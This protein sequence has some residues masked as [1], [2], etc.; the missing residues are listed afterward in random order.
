MANITEQ[1]W[2]SRCPWPTQIIFDRGIEFFG[3]AFKHEVM[4]NYGIKCKPITFRKPQANA[5]VEQ[6]HQVIRNIIRTFNLENNY[7]DE[8]NPFK[9]VLATTTF[10]VRS[11]YHITLKKMSGQLAFGCDMIFNVQHVASWDF[12]KQHK[13]QYIDKNNKAENA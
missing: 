13:Q 6:I 4:H 8:D 3:Y 10:A 12:I 11:T 5:I 2:L 1:E 9:R 7:L